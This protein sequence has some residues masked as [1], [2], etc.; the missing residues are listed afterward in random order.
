MPAERVC[1]GACEEKPGS[2]EALARGCVCPRDAN[3]GGEG[4]LVSTGGR[5][6]TYDTDCPL[7]F[8]VDPRAYVS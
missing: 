3:Q 2:P 8:P 7:H 4:R 6:F 1:A 5:Y